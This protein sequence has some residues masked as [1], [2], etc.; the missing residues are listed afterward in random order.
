MAPGNNE[1]RLI[2]CCCTY[3]SKYLVISV[4][5][6]YWWLMLF[7]YPHSLELLQGKQ[8]ALWVLSH[9][10]FTAAWNTMYSVNTMFLMKYAWLWRYMM[11]AAQFL[12]TPYAGSQRRKHHWWVRRWS[13]VCISDCS[14]VGKMAWGKVT[15]RH[16]YNSMGNISDHYDVVTWKNVMHYSHS[17]RLLVH[18]PPEGSAVW[19]FEG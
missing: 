17:H 1:C 16:R 9:L 19:C 14:R 3:A 5:F 12:Q 18:Y 6:I 11:V 15:K 2:F 13:V 8:S 10:Y 4:K 7:I